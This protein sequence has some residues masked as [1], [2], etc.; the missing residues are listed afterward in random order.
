[1]P[2]RFDIRRLKAKKK[3]PR[4]LAVDTALAW[5]AGVRAV[6]G[7]NT[8]RDWLA[9]DPVCSSSIGRSLT[10][11][12]GKAAAAMIRGCGPD[13]RGFAL[14]PQDQAVGAIP[15]AVQLLRASHPVPNDAGIDASRR[16]LAGVSA[17]GPGD[18]LLYLVSGGTSS[19]F[20]VPVDGIDARDL[21]AVY[22]LL[23]GCGAPIEEVNVIRAAISRVKGG[24]L[25]RAAGAA[26]VVTLAISDVHSDDPRIIG[27]GPTVD[28]G[29]D[30]HAARDLIAAR[31]LAQRLP[32]A[33]RNHLERGR[34][35]A[36]AGRLGSREYHVVASVR[37][38][39][40]ACRSF[41]ENAGY[42]V[43][44]PPMAHLR[45]DVQDAATAIASMIAT[46]GRS[47]GRCAFCVGGETTVTLP[48]HPGKGG[49]NCHLAALLALRLAGRKGFACTVGGSDGVD[50]AS[51]AAG[52]G[53]DGETAARA[54]AAGHALAE[55]VARFDTG[56]ALRACGAAL[57][58]ETTETN[59]G[60]LVVVAVDPALA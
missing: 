23:L 16:I 20:E 39:E 26:A 47:E 15:A 24:G 40:A 13:V 25:S 54:E 35:V 17:L 31:G 41:L 5:S 4:P 2:R 33:V 60:D 14:C 48:P 49:R 11:A 7:C 27:S 34:G 58:T 46:L 44:D 43:V 21:E 1:V 8:V 6:N 57:A 51:A 10:V 12:T 18:R 19:L 42:R 55:A 56:R 52:A 9:S 29:P 45:G 3:L 30:F 50:G 37:H 22:T 36:P 59:V 32:V 53:V 28:D 38:A